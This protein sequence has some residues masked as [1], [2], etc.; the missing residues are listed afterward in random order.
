MR[1][2]REITCPARLSHRAVFPFIYSMADTPFPPDGA[3]FISP[4]ATIAGRPTTLKT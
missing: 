3:T 4:V 2:L 1:E